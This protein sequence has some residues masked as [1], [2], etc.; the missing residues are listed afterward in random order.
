MT[1]ELKET[2]RMLDLSIQALENRLRV[3][4]KAD[5]LTYLEFSRLIMKLDDI[6]NIMLSDIEAPGLH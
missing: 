3:A 2:N 5:Y 1:I 4:V 6:I